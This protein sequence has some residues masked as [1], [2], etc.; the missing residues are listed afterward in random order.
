[1]MVK[2]VMSRNRIRPL[3]VDLPHFSIKAACVAIF[4]HMSDPFEVETELG[5]TVVGSLSVIENAVNSCV[6]QEILT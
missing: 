1:M 4:Q 3:R 2:H 6:M 5:K